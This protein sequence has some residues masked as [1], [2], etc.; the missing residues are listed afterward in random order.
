MVMCMKTNDF[1]ADQKEFG[2]KNEQH[3][4]VLEDAVPSHIPDVLAGDFSESK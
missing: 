4:R 3:G 1:L 2:C